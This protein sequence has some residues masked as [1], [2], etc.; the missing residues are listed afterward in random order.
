M[1][2]TLHYTNYDR[3][4][5]KLTDILKALFKKAADGFGDEPMF[6]LSKKFEEDECSSDVKISYATNGNDNMLTASKFL[7]SRMF[8]Y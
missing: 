5:E 1:I 2:K 4:P 7:M 6:T 3:D 8:Y